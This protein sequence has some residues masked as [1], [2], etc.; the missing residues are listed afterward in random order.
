MTTPIRHSSPRCARSIDNQ[1]RRKMCACKVNIVA[2]DAPV[3]FPI[4]KPYRA[5]EAADNIRSVSRH[6]SR[7]RNSAKWKSVYRKITKSFG[8]HGEVSTSNNSGGS[9]APAFSR[10]CMRVCI[11]REEG[12]RAFGKREW[13]IT[14]G[15]DRL[16]NERINAV[17]RVES[18]SRMCATIAKDSSHT[19]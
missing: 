2:H 15:E 5:E 1:E 17:E 16:W 18:T 10:V 6:E 12:W 19:K 13:E 11:C 7:R 14:R 9:L 3:Q 4:N 8:F